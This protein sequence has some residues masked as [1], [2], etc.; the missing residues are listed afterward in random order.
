MNTV[1]DI[2]SF[3]ELPVADREIVWDKRHYLR[4][5]PGALPKVLLAA[6]SWEYACLPALYGLL[7][8]WSRPQPMDILQ[9]FLPIFPDVEVRQCAIDWMSE[10]GSDELVDYLPQLL[11]ALKHETWSVS[12][13]AKLL[14]QRS[15]QSP[16]VA[17]S[18][19]WLLTQVFNRIYLTSKVIS[20]GMFPFEFLSEPSWSNS[21]KHDS[22]L[23]SDCHVRR[24]P[25]QAGALSEKVAVPDEG[26]FHD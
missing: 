26:T 23:L 4:S 1:Q 10:I 13:L 20:F 2:M 15:L 22:A 18:L 8:T 17:H 3:T 16:R 24:F 5:I 6:H 9:L 25:S 21:S 12:P 11:E 19:Y 7:T 14:L